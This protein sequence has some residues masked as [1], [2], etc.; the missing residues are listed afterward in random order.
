[1]SRPPQTWKHAERAIAR[2]LG[3]C[4]CHFEGKDVDAGRW[5]AEVKHGRQ[6]PK[7]IIDW[8]DQ[9]EKN[10]R[11]GERPLLVLHPPRIPYEESLVV[12]RLGDFVRAHDAGDDG[13]AHSPRIVELVR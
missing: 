4:R 13:K 8:F 10:A 11:D 9:A 7:T 3:G 12:L 5:S 1:M 2:L 6:V